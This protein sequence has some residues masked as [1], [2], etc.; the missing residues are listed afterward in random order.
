MLEIRRSNT[1]D[2]SAIVWVRV[3]SWRAANRGIVPDD[4]LDGIEAAQW[5]DG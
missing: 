5:A 4:F 1:S 2:A 3:E